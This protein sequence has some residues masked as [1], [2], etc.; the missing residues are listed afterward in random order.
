MVSLGG[1]R[2]D[3]YLPSFCEVGNICGLMKIRTIG[4]AMTR[5]KARIYGKAVRGTTGLWTHRSLSS[6]LLLPKGCPCIRSG[7]HRAVWCQTVCIRERWRRYERWL[8]DVWRGYRTIDETRLAMNRV[9]RAGDRKAPQAIIRWVEDVTL[10]VLV[11]SVKAK[12]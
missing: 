6:W 2:R 12:D 7:C 1:Q 3:L 9:L 4:W 11:E 10:V 5:R 8:T